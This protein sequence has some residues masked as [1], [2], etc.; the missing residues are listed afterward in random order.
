MI[1]GLKVSLYV[2]ENSLF[3][4]GQEQRRRSMPIDKVYMEKFPKV[5]LSLFRCI[6]S[7][8]FR[9]KSEVKLGL[10][11]LDSDRTF[12]GKD[13][14]KNTILRSNTFPISSAHYTEQI[15]DEDAKAQRKAFEISYRATSQLEKA[16]SKD[17]SETM[18][19]TIGMSVFSFWLALFRSR[20]LPANLHIASVVLGLATSVDLLLS[21]A[22][23]MRSLHNIV[24]LYLP[25]PG[26]SI[27]APIVGCA[28]CL[29]GQPKLLAL[30]A[31]LNVS[32][33]LVT[34]PL[35][36]GF[37]WGLKTLCLV[38][39]ETI[40]KALVAIF[41]S[42]VITKLRNLNYDKYERKFKGEKLLTRLPATKAQDEEQPT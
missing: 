14:L 40:I 36:L 41:S 27:M 28:G 6:R 2:F 33:I 34:L 16:I 5:Y 8:L 9:A 38:V 23:L 11:F 24:Y 30:Y 4:D 29:T 19:T 3:P 17:K 1:S 42:P 15:S 18:L 39:C 35:Y 25:V 22:L 13:K 32:L 20:S 7:K 21:S 26:L 31:D 12:M 10:E 37:N